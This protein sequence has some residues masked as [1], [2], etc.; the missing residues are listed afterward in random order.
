M[1]LLGGDENLTVLG[2]GTGLDGFL[3]LGWLLTDGT[4]PSYLR[5]HAYLQRSPLL[6]YLCEQIKPTQMMS[7]DRENMEIVR[8][9]F[10]PH[11]SALSTLRRFHVFQDPSRALPKRVN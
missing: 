2:K 6:M 3:G 11:E 1:M 7:Y 5:I 4:L 8:K 9:V 10:T